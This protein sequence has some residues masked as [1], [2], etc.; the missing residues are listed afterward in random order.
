MHTN[1][2]GPEYMSQHAIMLL[3]TKNP[4]HIRQKEYYEVA[5]VLK[6]VQFHL[7]KSFLV[8]NYMFQ[9]Q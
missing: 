2:A 9:G 4:K 3:E 8:T 5:N 6:C 7:Y 1:K